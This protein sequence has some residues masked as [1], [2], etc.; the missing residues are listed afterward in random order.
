M[1]VLYNTRSRQLTSIIS[2]NYLTIMSSLNTNIL[3]SFINQKKMQY[4]SDLKAATTQMSGRKFIVI[5]KIK[6][7]LMH[8]TNGAS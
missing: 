2:H 4:V 5:L 7:D 3:P 8:K 6:Y 1:V